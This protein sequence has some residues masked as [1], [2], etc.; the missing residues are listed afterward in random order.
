MPDGVMAVMLACSMV[1]PGTSITKQPS[2]TCQATTTSGGSGNAFAVEHV[3]ERKQNGAGERQR[4]AGEFCEPMERLREEFMSNRLAAAELRLPIG[5][6]M[7]RDAECSPQRGVT[8][9]GVACRISAG[10]A[11]PT[12]PP[13]GC[14]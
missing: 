14:M 7:R 6:C 12:H 2:P 13:E 10:C 8:P 4:D 3:A 5:G 1:M 11:R 9:S